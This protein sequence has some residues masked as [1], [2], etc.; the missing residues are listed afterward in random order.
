M[1]FEMRKESMAWISHGLQISL[2]RHALSIEDKMADEAF[3]IMGE[4]TPL[5]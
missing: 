1:V 3:G 4:T 2:K 5:M